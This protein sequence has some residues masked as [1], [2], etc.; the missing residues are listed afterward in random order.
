M[1]LGKFEFDKGDVS[2]ILMIFFA[3]FAMF[4]LGY[5]YAYGQAIEYANEEIDSIISEYETQNMVVNLGKTYSDNII[6]NYE[7]I[8]A[9]P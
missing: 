8:E 7:L 6:D 3:M 1:K 5:R 9:T 4:M 2:V